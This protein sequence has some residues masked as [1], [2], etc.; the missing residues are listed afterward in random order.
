MI[1]KQIEKIFPYIEENFITYPLWEEGNFTPFV[2][3]WQ[4]VENLE[5][6]ENLQKKLREFHKKNEYEIYCDGPSSPMSK[7][8]SFSMCPEYIELEDGGYE[9]AKRDWNIEEMIHLINE[10]IKK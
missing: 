5:E 3:F 8:Y 10:F 4:S 7:I 2:N 9:Y 6:L 1:H